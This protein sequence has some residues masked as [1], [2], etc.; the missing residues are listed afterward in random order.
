MQT[1]IT[2][3]MRSRTNRRP[4]PVSTTHARCLF[5][6]LLAATMALS[7]CRVSN[8]AVPT[9]PATLSGNWQ[10][11]MAAPADGSFE[12]GLEGGFLL[13]TNGSATGSVAYSI[14]LPNN[15]TP[16]VCNSGSAAITE[17]LTASSGNQAVSI[18]AVADT[19][20]FTLTGTLSFD[21][22]T[23]AGTY[24]STSGTAADGTP[25]GTAQSGLQWSAIL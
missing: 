20:T 13:Q 4:Q 5:L 25:C 10:F 19:Q 24:N 2:P 11:T 3:R 8:P 17:T 16:T 21:G 18:T 6:L 22:S 23:M 15:P 12:G 7:A 14:A 9:V 1:L